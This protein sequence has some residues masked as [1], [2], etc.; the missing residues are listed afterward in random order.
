M[1]SIVIVLNAV[2]FFLGGGGG[3]GFQNKLVAAGVLPATSS[4]A[5]GYFSHDNKY[6][7]AN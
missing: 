2:Y 7:S 5:A 3:Q 1:N 6:M 4:F